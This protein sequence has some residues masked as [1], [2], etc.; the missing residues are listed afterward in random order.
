MKLSDAIMDKQLQW[1]KEAILFCAAHG[2]RGGK[3]DTFKWANGQMM[4]EPV[5]EDG[6]EALPNQCITVETLNQLRRNGWKWFE[7]EFVD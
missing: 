3:F 5:L 6:K 1:Q 2:K 4:A 7:L